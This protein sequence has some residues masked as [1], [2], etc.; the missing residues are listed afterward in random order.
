M[1]GAPQLTEDGLERTFALNHMSYFVMMLGLKERLFASAHA[2]VV[3][4]ASDAH[5]SG[6]L[7]L[8]DLNSDKFYP[9]SIGDKLRYGGPPFRV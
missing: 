2:R 6:W 9:G 7:D 1:F 5:E 8:E 3:N 4:T